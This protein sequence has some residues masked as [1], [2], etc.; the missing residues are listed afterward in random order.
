LNKK[1]KGKGSMML[2]SRKQNS[3]WA[4]SVTLLFFLQSIRGQEEVGIDICAC[5]P[6][7]YEI[8]LGTG[9]ICEDATVEGPGIVEIA[10]LVSSRLPDT[11]NVTDFVPVTVS[12]IQVLEL[13]EFQD[14]IGQSVYTDG[15]YFDGD[16]VT[17]TSIVR[18][19]PDIITPTTLPRGLQVSIVG[20]NARNQPIVNTWA[21]LYS[22]DCGIF[23]LLTVGQVI[24]WSIFVSHRKP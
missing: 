24:G 21:I 22:N 2:C 8:T 6:S 4:L 7:V 18:T 12:E 9:L 13:D 17:Y 10:C 11:V 19:Q 3:T 1:G 23:P 16:F 20:N 14:P 5:Q 15:P